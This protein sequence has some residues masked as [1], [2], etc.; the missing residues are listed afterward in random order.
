[1][2]STAGVTAGRVPNQ[3][4]IDGT[5]HTVT[6]A[7]AGQNINTVD[8]TVGNEFLLGERY[9]FNVRFNGGIREFPAETFGVGKYTYDEGTLRWV[10]APGQWTTEDIQDL[11]LAEARAGNTDAWS[12]DK[13]G[14][15]VGTQAQYDALTTAQR[16]P[17]NTFNVVP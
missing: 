17:Y 3:V 10:E 7:I 13:T 12:N 16:A 9:T 1:M 2:V 15:W 11:M 6:L 8:G 14:V 5:R 4:V